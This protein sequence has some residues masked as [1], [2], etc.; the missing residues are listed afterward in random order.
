MSP[1]PLG[2]GA[3]MMPMMGVIMMMMMMT[4]TM[5][6]VTEV[7]EQLKCLREEKSQVLGRLSETTKEKQALDRKCSQV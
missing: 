7:E 3:V 5:L 6:Q 2:H 1:K 4:R